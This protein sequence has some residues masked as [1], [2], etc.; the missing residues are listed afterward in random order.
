MPT[1]KIIRLKNIFFSVSW[2]APDLNSIDLP[3][4]GFL[5]LD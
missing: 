2:V 1:E 4:R 5:I 3:I